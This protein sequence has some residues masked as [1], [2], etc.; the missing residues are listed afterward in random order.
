[1]I[2]QTNKVEQATEPDAGR[3]AETGEA[4]LGCNRS[5]KRR[6]WERLNPRHR[7]ELRLLAE[8]LAMQQNHGRLPEAT[9]SRLDAALG[10]LERVVRR[11]AAILTEVARRTPPAR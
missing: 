11:I 6:L 2:Q 9:R 10:E 8:A 1:M 7:K 4:W 3:P 5:D